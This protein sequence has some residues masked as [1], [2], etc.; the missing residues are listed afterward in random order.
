MLEYNHLSLEERSHFL[1]HGWLRIPNAINPAYLDPWLDNLWVRL[2]MKADDKS[3]W[4]D[5]FLKLPRHREVPNEEMCTDDAWGK[6]LEI[7]G[8]EEKMHPYRERY[9]GDQFIINFGNEH[10]EQHDQIPTQAKGW[11]VDNDWYRQFLDSGGIALTLI[12]LYSDC[13]ARGGGTY[14]CE[15]AIPGG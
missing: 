7:V 8:G 2:G 4:T 12:F 3:T 10:W 14:V 9:F 11:H 6:V 1:E 15:D 5:E 13:P